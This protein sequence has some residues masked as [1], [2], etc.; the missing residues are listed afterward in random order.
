MDQNYKCTQC[1][2]W[3]CG[4][5]SD[6]AV[7]LLYNAEITV[8]EGSN[9]PYRECFSFIDK[10]GIDDDKMTKVVTDVY[11]GRNDDGYLDKMKNVRSVVGLGKTSSTGQTDR[12]AAGEGG[13]R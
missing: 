13:E 6:I 5:I 1:L 12:R 9:N 8:C 11:N 4:K 10:Q 7:D 2:R 3:K